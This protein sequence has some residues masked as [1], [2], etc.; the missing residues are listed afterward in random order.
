MDKFKNS[1]L[2]K[3]FSKNQDH[4]AL[5]YENKYYTYKQLCENILNK[6]EI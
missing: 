2:N 1:F 3:V 6:I 5:I 4:Y